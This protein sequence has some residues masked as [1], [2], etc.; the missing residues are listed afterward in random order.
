MEQ[1]T[2]SSE[3]NKQVNSLLK[4]Q[5]QRLE[6]QLSA[7]GTGQ[8]YAPAVRNNFYFDVPQFGQSQITPPP[9][10]GQNLHGILPKHDSASPIDFSVSSSSVPKGNVLDQSFMSHPAPNIPVESQYNGS[11]Q[12]QAFAPGLTQSP[13]AMDSFAG[14]FSPSLINA[15]GQSGVGSDY[16]FQSAPSRTSSLQSQSHG[17]VHDSGTDSNSGLTRVF[18]FNSSSG[19]TTSQSESPSLSPFH[20]ISSTA[21]S[22]EP[23]SATTAPKPVDARPTGDIAGLATSALSQTM[24][25]P[26]TT[27]LD[28]LV[29]QNNGQFDP[30]LL[31]DYRE[32]QDAI[33]GDGDFNNG[34]FDDAFLYDMSSPFNAGLGMTSKPQTPGLAAAYQTHMP[35]ATASQ[36]LLQQL[37]KPVEYEHH[38]SSG[39]TVSAAPTHIDLGSEAQPKTGEEMMTCDAVWRKLQ[40]ISDFKEGKLDLDLL[41]DEMRA[42]VTCTETGML[43]PAHAVTEALEKMNSHRPVKAEPST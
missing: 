27:S 29:S 18:R 20:N 14:L 30:V 28:R 9:D 31:G 15:A 33:I 26:A 2:K 25:E 19:A 13:P 41:C 37:D 1:L 12:A 6:N 32:S 39:T 11:T 34:F 3:K 21:T 17:Q 4:S 36:K 43:M 23:L 22:P 5:I 24:A 7:Q 10:A 16:G 40:A 35:A 42:K 8:L 38:T